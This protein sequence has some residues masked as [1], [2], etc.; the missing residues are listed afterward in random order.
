[1]LTTIGRLSVLMCALT[2]LTACAP[3]LALMGSGGSVIQIAAQ[4]DRLKLVAD[5]VSYVNSRKTLTDRALSMAKGAD[6]RIFNVVTGAPVCVPRNADTTI[7]SLTEE[8]APAASDPD[9]SIA[10]L[11]ADATP[12]TGSPDTSLASFTEDATQ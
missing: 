12:A 8:A 2:C 9:T 6:C 7:A 4:L 3:M 1:M 10:A 5:G 11:T